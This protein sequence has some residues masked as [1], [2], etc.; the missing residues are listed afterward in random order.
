MLTWN[1]WVCLYFRPIV[2]ISEGNDPIISP[3]SSSSSEAL[4]TLSSFTDSEEEA[5][6]QRP[7][8][9]KNYFSVQYILN[10][11]ATNLSVEILEPNL[12]VIRG[13]Q[14]PFPNAQPEDF[15]KTFLL[16]RDYSIHTIVSNISPAG[17]MTVTTNP[18]P[19]P[20]CTEIPIYWND[21]V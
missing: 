3:S 8:E 18:Y 20:G 21:D 10:P 7:V 11:D 5:C 14:S 12:V 6:A 9:K 17:V 16:P 15:M 13:V 2:E 1:L 19:Q 4:S